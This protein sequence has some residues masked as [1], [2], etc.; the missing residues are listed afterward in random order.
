MNKDDFLT[1]EQ[2]AEFLR[3]K[4][5]T[6]TKNRSLGVQHPPYIKIGRTVLYP[7][8]NFK[9]WIKSQPLHQEIVNVR[10]SRTV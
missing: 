10:R 2:V 8:S 9:E 3:W 4:K 6:L 7:I 5:S 1:E